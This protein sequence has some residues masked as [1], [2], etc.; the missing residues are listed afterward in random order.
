MR[1]I[2]LVALAPLALA[3]CQTTQ[4][5]PNASWGRSDIYE[6]SLISGSTI[7]MDGFYNLDRSC[8]NIGYARLRVVSP[9]SG[10]TVFSKQEA[11][12]PSYTRDNQRFKCNQRRA[13]TLGVYYKASPQFTGQD[14]MDVEIF[15]TD[16]DVWKYKLNV[17]V[18]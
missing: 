1:R 17:N 3:A 13:P 16:G 18:K 8:K 12:F 14:T 15:W 6:R 10:G 5:N 4:L 11:D 9:P 7:R 2:L